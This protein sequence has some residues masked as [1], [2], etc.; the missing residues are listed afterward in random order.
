MQVEEDMGW[1]WWRG[2]RV[3]GL[4][5][6]LLLCFLCALAHATGEVWDVCVCVRG[7]VVCW[8]L[9]DKSVEV[10]M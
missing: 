7:A 6:L 3:V 4:L 9:S 1:W 8:W 10:M 5:L 2:T